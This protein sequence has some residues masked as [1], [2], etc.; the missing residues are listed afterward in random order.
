MTRRGFIATIIALL[1]G[2]KI[3][4]TS[5]AKYH[6]IPIN[7]SAKHLKRAEVYELGKKP[8]YNLC[9]VTIWENG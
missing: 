5:W 3:V 7:I 6:C 1:F 8:P 9:K 4:D 2:A